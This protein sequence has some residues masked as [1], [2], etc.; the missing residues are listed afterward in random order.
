MTAN[1]FN[2]GMLGNL[3]GF[4]FYKIVE[5]RNYPFQHMHLDQKHTVKLPVEYFLGKA[6]L[7]SRTQILGILNT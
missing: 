1:R 6:L 3:L 2:L 7:P 5:K 4:K